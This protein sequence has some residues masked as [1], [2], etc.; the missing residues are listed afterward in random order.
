MTYN[1]W[2]IVLIPFPFT[3]LSINKKRPG[4][5]I[6]QNES[7]QQNFDILIAFMTSNLVSPKRTGDFH[8]EKWEESS[9]PKPTML[10]MKFAS[11]SSHI[12]VKKIGQLHEDDINGFRRSFC[13]YFDHII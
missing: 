5:V 2:D 9:L 3:D 13:S 7:N 1:C 11:I 8:I 10:R 6:S 4:L 12:I